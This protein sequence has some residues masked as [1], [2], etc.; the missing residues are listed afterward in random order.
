MTR[1]LDPLF[2]PVPLLLNAPKSKVN[3]AELEMQLTPT[4][5]LF[6]SAA[7]SYID[8]E[9]E[10]FKGSGFDGTEIDFAG[11]AFNFAPLVQYTLLADYEFRAS[12]DY[13]IGL[14]ADYSYTDETNS[15][16]EGNPNYAHR[17]FGLV[18]ARVRLN[19]ARSIWSL[20]LWGRNLTDEFSQ[21]S[22]FN[23]GDAVARYAGIPRTYGV[24]LSYHFE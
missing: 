12:K 16:L 6:L 11:R 9:I 7:G 19:D 18:N 14:S 15:T 17:D 4:E 21:V 1:K 8:T 20:M 10:E 23:I 3:G 13:L 2:G 5:G 22:V 24:T